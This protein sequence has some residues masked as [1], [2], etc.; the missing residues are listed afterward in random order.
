MNSAE[1]YQTTSKEAAWSGSSLFAILTSILL[2]WALI[3]H[4]FFENS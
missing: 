4:I 1:P 3:I 2:I